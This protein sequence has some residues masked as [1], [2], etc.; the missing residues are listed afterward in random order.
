M[1]QLLFLL[2]LFLS[3]PY[4]FAFNSFITLEIIVLQDETI[5]TNK[6]H[7]GDDKSDVVTRLNTI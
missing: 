5:R 3:I 6:L 7:S 2:K 4:F 1:K